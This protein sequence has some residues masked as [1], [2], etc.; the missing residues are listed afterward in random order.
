[1]NKIIDYEIVIGFDLSDLE[2]DVR[3]MILDGY[4]PY[5]T[6]FISLQENYLQPMVKYEER[7][8]EC[9]HFW[10]NISG[11]EYGYLSEQCTFCDKVRNRF[12]ESPEMKAPK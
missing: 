3:K 4:Q 1:M 11:Y 6:P 8:L 10:T 9:E 12:V 7:K 2:I 5:G